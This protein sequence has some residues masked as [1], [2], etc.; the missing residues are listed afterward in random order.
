MFPR[1][2]F[3]RGGSYGTYNS[4]E[5]LATGSLPPAPFCTTLWT[6][7]GGMAPFAGARFAAPDRSSSAWA[8]SFARTNRCYFDNME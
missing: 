3:K 1:T 5:G 6:G 4:L 7:D 8:T 2:V